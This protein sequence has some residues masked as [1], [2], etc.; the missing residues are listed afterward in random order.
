MPGKKE[1]NRLSVEPDK[2]QPTAARARGLPARRLRW[3]RKGCFC[4]LSRFLEDNR[5][6]RSARIHGASNRSPR[7]PVRP[8]FATR[9]NVPRMPA[10]PMIK[11]GERTLLSYVI[12]PLS[13]QVS[14][15]FREE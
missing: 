13:D 5:A 1:V 12:K 10:E 3:V 2:L 7:R 11:T 9:S 8:I 6:G 14:R 15:A 4:A